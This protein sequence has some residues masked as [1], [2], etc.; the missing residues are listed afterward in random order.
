[1][2]TDQ[3]TLDIL[4]KMIRGKRAILESV[5]AKGKRYSISKSNVNIKSTKYITFTDPLEL[6]FSSL[7]K[8][9][10]RHYS[11]LCPLQSVSSDTPIS[12]DN[13][14]LGNISMRMI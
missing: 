4:V 9:Q 5:N 14:S 8:D 7:P 10:S 3:N 1:M 13:L 11:I 6:S 2:Y 12:V